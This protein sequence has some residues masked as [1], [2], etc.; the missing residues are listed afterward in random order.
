MSVARVVVMAF[1]QKRF[2]QGTL[3]ECSVEQ[4]CM[5]CTSVEYDRHSFLGH[6]VNIAN[7]NYLT[8]DD[9]WELCLMR[10]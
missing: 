7:L 1:K 8:S 4:T 10:S 2:A 9:G 3:C 5:N 6:Y